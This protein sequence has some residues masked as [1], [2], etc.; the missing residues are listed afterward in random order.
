MGVIVPLGDPS[1]HFWLTR[2]VAR[3]MGLSFTD[4]MAEG[5]LSAQEYAA[6]ITRCRTCDHVAECQSWLGAMAEKPADP[7]EFCCHGPLMTSLAKR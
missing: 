5:H 4:A 3:K 6:M 2:S 1:V 7:P